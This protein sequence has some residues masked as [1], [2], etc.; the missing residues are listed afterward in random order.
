MR[1]DLSESSALSA[2]RWQRRTTLHSRPRNPFL[3]SLP[4]RNPI[5]VRVL[6]PACFFCYDILFMSTSFTHC[7]FIYVNVIYSLTAA[8]SFDPHV[9]AVD[10]DRSTSVLRDL[11]CLFL[12]G[13]SWFA[14]STGTPKINEQQLRVPYTTSWSL[15]TLMKQF[16]R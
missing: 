6:F 5:G 9:S 10:Y 3:W 12:V 4:T 1:D 8:L 15:F 2:E 14:Y 7:Y 16:I 13:V 11:S